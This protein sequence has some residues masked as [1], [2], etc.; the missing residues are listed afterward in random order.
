[1]L[2]EP[3]LPMSAD[4]LRRTKEKAQQLQTE[5]SL[6]ELPPPGPPTEPAP[7]LA[8]AAPPLAQDQKALLPNS[9]TAPE[10]GILW[11]RK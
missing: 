6:H 4:E 1:M 3:T 10:H 5:M 9:E 8:P 2:D 11:V 7:F